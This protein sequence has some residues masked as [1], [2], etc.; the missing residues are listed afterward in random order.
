[1]FHNV[2]HCFTMFHIQQ[3]RPKSRAHIK[4][5]PSP[6]HTTKKQLNSC[7]ET[8]KGCQRGSCHRRRAIVPT[9]A[10]DQDLERVTRHHFGVEKHWENLEKSM[11]R[12]S[13]I[14]DI[15]WIFYRIFD[16]IRLY[17]MIFYDI[18]NAICWNSDMENDLSR[19]CCG[20]SWL[21]IFPRKPRYFNGKPFEGPQLRSPTRRPSCKY[22][23]LW[24]V[25]MDGQAAAHCWWNIHQEFIFF[26]RPST[27]TIYIM[28]T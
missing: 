11:G 1:M 27:C 18:R 20:N 14:L 28:Y 6:W 12:S 23:R 8:I 13:I 10:M 24:V 3:V 4:S 26:N 16:D 19:Q 15:R 5:P 17:S 9:S 21:T 7:Q 2:S 22:L 25:H